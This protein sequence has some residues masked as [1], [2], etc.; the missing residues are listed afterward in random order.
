MFKWIDGNPYDI[1]L[2]FVI[3]AFY[4]WAKYS[5]NKNKNEKIDH[6]SGN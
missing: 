2:F 3:V 1:S 4:G 6:S 5:K